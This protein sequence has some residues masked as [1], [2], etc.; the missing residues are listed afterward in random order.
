MGMVKLIFLIFYSC[1]GAAASLLQLAVE[2]LAN[3]VFQHHGGLRGG[4]GVAL[5]QKALVGPR[6]DADVRSPSKPLVR[7]CSELS[8]GNW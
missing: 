1:R 7:I 5:G 8:L 4:D 3:Q 6:A 2:E